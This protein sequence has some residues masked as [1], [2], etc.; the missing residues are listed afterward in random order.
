MPSV[1]RLPDHEMNARIIRA[2]EVHHWPR[3]PE[4]A[5]AREQL[6]H[7]LGAIEPEATPHERRRA[8]AAALRRFE[9]AVAR[10]GAK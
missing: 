4:V 8:R 1:K 6:S 2:L 5:A 7:E 3:T 9:A 10:R